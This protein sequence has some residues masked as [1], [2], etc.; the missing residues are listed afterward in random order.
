VTRPPPALASWSV[1]AVNQESGIPL[2][3][4]TYSVLDASGRKLFRISREK[5]IAGIADGAFVPVGRTCVKYL[6]INSAADPARSER[7]RAAKTWIGPRNPGEGALTVYEHNV[8]MCDAWGP[9][10]KQDRG[11]PRRQ[12]L[13]AR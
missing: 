9:D 13:T 1:L 10:P 2:L 4:E 3:A 5:A 7:H 12:T 6:R 11:W 8:R